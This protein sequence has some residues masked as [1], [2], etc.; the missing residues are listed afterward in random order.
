MSLFDCTVPVPA[1]LDRPFARAI[2]VT[3]LGYGKQSAPCRS[4]GST[5]A[6]RV[7]CRAGRGL[8]VL[9]DL[10]HI[11]GWELPKDSIAVA[12]VVAAS[13]TV[14]S[15]VIRWLQRDGPML[16]QYPN[17]RREIMMYC[18]AVSIMLGILLGKE[19]TRL[20]HSPCTKS[21]QTEHSNLICPRMSWFFESIAWPSCS[22]FCSAAYTC[23]WGASLD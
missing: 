7:Y 17:V 1:L 2:P 10:I 4:C 13:S 22:Q 23:I 14:V 11:R 6:L 16:K 19:V 12:D 9:S 21:F 5:W 20:S 18:S 8:D 15:H 3:G